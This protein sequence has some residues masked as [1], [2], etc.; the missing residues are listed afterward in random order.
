MKEQLV[1][2]AEQLAN[3]EIDTCKVEKES[4]QMFG[5][6]IRTRPDFKHFRGIAQK[7][8][9]VIYEFLDEPRS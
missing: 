7:G 1:S 4:M 3:K 6:I 8:G 2:I 9:S 5:Q